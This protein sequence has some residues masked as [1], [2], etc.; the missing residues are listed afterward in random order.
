MPPNIPT[1]TLGGKQFW[2]DLRFYGAWRIQQHVLTGHC[3][4]LDG[5]MVRRS[6]GSREECDGA[7]ADVIATGKVKIETKKACLLVHGYIRS[8]DSLSTMKAHLEANGY[9]V[10]DVGYPSAQTDL[11]SLVAQLKAVYESTGED[12]ER[13]DWV[14]HSLGGILARGV[15]TQ[16]ETLPVET[17][18]VMMGPPNQGAVMADLL[19]GWW[20]SEY[21]LGPV[22]KDLGKKMEAA[23]Q[24]LGTP[25]C[26]VGIIAGAKGT[27]GGWNPLI[28]GDDDGVVGVESTKLEGMKDWISVRALHTLIMNHPDT[29]AQVV[30]FLDKG[31]FGEKE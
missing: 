12:F 17:R 23:V 24:T 22:G 31:A 15:L 30:R 4:L 19:L 27:E 28:P 9:T 18:V 21:I 6:W 11:G 16:Y 1:K 26:D 14:T 5:G 8:K 25:K 7:L 10:Y 2:G 3:R 20:P 13:V 29:L